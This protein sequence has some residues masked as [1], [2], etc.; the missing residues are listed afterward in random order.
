MSD[1]EAVARDLQK[2]IDEEPVMRRWAEATQRRNLESLQRAQ[3][4]GGEALAP[5]EPATAK[6]KGHDQVGFD[7]GEMAAGLT[8]PGAINLRF[9]GD[10]AV[11]E[12]FGGPGS[13]D[14]ELNIFIKGKPAE[15]RWQSAQAPSGK[16][17]AWKYQGSPVPGRD[18]FGV[19]ERD[20][21]KAGEDLLDTVAKTWG[22]K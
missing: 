8:A 21:D 10:E 13:T 3:G 4:P 18:F 22:F 19:D 5:N 17:K 9:G 11:A 2:P 1:L 7:S 15:E 20:V 6:R 16:R 12:V 14:K